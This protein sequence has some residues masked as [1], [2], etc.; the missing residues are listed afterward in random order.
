LP[1]TWSPPAAQARAKTFAEESTPLPCG[2]PISQERS[3]TCV[4]AITASTGEPKGEGL[5]GALAIAD[6]RKTRVDV[7]EFR[8]SAR[9][10]KWDANAPY[11]TFLPGFTVRESDRA[12][13]GRQLVSRPDLRRAASRQDQLL[14]ETFHELES[15]AQGDFADARDLGDRLLRAPLAGRQRCEVDGGRGGPRGGQGHRAVDLLEFLENLVGLGL[16]RVAQAESRAEAT[17]VVGRPR[18]RHSE[19]EGPQEGA[20]GL[21]DRLLPDA[22]HLLQL[23]EGP[24]HAVDPAR[25]VHRG[26][27]DGLD[28]AAADESFLQ[29]L[30]ADE[31]GLVLHRP[32]EAHQRGD[33]VQ[34]P[35]RLGQTAFSGPR[36][37]RV[38]LQ[39]PHSGQTRCSSTTGSAG[40]VVGMASLIARGG[41][42]SL[43]YNAFILYLVIVLSDS[44]I[45]TGWIGRDFVTCRTKD[46]LMPG[47]A[48]DR[49]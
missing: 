23:V 39:L 28:R 49:S 1:N 15:I 24:R 16:D 36:V 25:G 13:S 3:L 33:A 42:I 41:T 9:P 46:V 17:H 20:V 19:G 12:N 43:R 38:S 8:P 47:D 27:D 37:P 34:G 26:G 4:A 10:H 44:L 11:Q 45:V 35:N 32:R 5:L 21:A 2:P 6:A 48:A 22:R 7:R 40:V 14:H 31:T 29:G 30:L 18:R